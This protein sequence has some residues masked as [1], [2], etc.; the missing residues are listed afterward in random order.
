MAGGLVM[1]DDLTVARFFELFSTRDLN[2]LE[3]LLTE[4]AEYHFL[5]T[6]PL[7]GK[8][9]ILRFFKILFRQ[10]PEPEFQVQRK[11]IQGNKAAVHWVNRGVNKKGE[12]YDN[13]GVTILEM[14]GGKI[15]W[16]RDHRLAPNTDQA[17][18]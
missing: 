11:I 7:L 10:Y 17:E 1:S 14:E 12:P 13:E 18:N 6:Q 8:G 5:K 4:N 9:Q 2:K 3:E 15:G 16:L